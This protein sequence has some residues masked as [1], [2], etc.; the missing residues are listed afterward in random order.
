MANER[1]AVNRTKRRSCCLTAIVA[2]VTLVGGCS[3]ADKQDEELISEL[4]ELHEST[5]AEA[6]T[7]LQK[8]EDEY[9]QLRKTLIATIEKARLEQLRIAGHG[10]ARAALM[11]SHWELMADNTEKTL[12]RGLMDAF[13]SEQFDS[14]FIPAT[15]RAN[16]PPLDEFETEL[17]NR[18]ASST[19]SKD[20]KKDGHAPFAE[21]RSPVDGRYEY[22]EPSFFKNDCFACHVRSGRPALSIGDGLSEP[23]S[24]RVGDLIAIVKI[25]LK[26]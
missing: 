16:D 12:V 10:A 14:A 24:Y 6:E 23:E 17:L 19:S 7:A 18:F 3:Q 2:A 11:T 13:R 1:I 20:E 25:R 5:K 4:R 8:Q 15:R 21:R 22:Y 26:E 9:L